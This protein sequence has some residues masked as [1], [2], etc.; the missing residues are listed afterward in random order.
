MLVTTEKDA[1]RMEPDLNPPLPM[2]YLRVEIEIITGA[3]DFGEAVTRIAGRTER[4]A[5]TTPPGVV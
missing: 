3:A 4:S 2:Y 1:V 5:P